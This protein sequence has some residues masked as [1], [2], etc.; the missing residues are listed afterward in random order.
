MRDSQFTSSEPL[1]N[2][3]Y[4]D[5]SNQA[6]RARFHEFYFAQRHNGL[7][8]IYDHV[9]MVEATKYGKWGVQVDF[10]TPMTSMQTT[11]I[12][13]NWPILRQ[14]ID[15]RMEEDGASRFRDLVEH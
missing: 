15:V 12:E 5:P 4:Q 14:A 8:L 2:P 7:V 9:P 13:D 3:P 6:K 10:I 1:R 11:L